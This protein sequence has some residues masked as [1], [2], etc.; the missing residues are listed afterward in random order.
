MGGGGE[1]ERYS[2]GGERV[3]EEDEGEH[4]KEMMDGMT[5]FKEDLTVGTVLERISRN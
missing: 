5:K 3:D 1:S 4:E 2:E